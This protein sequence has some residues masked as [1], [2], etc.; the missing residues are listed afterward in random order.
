VEA[1][2]TADFKKLALVFEDLKSERKEMLNFVDFY[3]SLAR[4]LLVVEV[5]EEKL[6]NHDLK[7][8]LRKLRNKTTPEQIHHMFIQ[9]AKSY[10]NIRRNANKEVVL[11]PLLLPFYP[12]SFRD[13]VKL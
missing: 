6:I 12:H 10:R 2:L 9:G 7:G 1:L 13:I 3:L 8:E 4:D 11:Y 5:S